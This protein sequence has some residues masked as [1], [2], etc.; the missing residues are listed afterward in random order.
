MLKD[1]GILS[2][3][4]SNKFACEGYGVKLREFLLDKTTLLEFVDLN[5][6]KVFEKATVDTSIVS[7]IKNKANK[8]H[9]LNYAN[10]SEKDLVALTYTQIPQSKL[11]KEAFI[12]GDDALFELKSKIEQ[13]GTPLK[14]WDIAINYGIKTGYNEAFIIDTQT[15]E[16]ILNSCKDESE[17]ER[18]AK[19]IKPILRGRDIN[20]YRYE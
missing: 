1:G 18:T 4:T 5:D 20:L 11:I 2:F 9:K 12:F 7:F 10:P 15:K 19:L 14:E 13:V 6:L 3:I 17:R 8:I 16:A